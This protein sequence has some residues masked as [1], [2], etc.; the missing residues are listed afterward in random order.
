[1]K[2]TCTITSLMGL[3]SISIRVF[4]TKS[5][6]QTALLIG[7]NEGSEL[8]Q[9]LWLEIDETQIGSQNLPVLESNFETNEHEVRVTDKPIRYKFTTP[10]MALN[11]KNHS[12]F[13]ALT[14][15]LARQDKLART[16]AS[17][18]LGMCKSLGLRR[19]ET[20]ERIIADCQRIRSIK[21]TLKG[22]RMLAFVGQ[23]T[24]N[25]D[26]PDHIGIGKSV[27]RGFGTIEKA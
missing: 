21:T 16:L 8:L 19:F 27:S 3:R 12:E 25:L 2:F 23:F 5:S 1:M 26:L 10:W 11:Q 20:H 24:L 18:C 14:N 9:R 4:N 22:Q 15:K 13:A 17:N 6:T 7:V